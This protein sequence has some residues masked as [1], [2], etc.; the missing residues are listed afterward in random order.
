MTHIILILLVTQF[1]AMM[2]PGPD[3]LLV[4]KNTLGQTSNKAGIYTVLGI[5]LGLAV[6][7]ALSIAGLAILLTESEFLYQSVRYAGAAYLGYLG[8]KSILSHSEN[9][10]AV[11]ESAPIKRAGEAFREGLFTNLSNPKV[12]LYILSLFTQLIDP[13]SPLWEKVTYGALLVAEA[14]LVWLVFSCLVK[15]PGFQ[16]SGR[17]W[18]PWIERLFGLI[19]LG[20]ALSVVYSG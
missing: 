17:N 20:I 1:F 3:M 2:S 9:R 4:M 16:S 14:I 5:G 11:N 13:A 19:L 15:M 18:A 8:L 6:H 7:I 10:N 12:A